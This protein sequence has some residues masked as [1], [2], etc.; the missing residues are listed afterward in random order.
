M[1]LAGAGDTDISDLDSLDNVDIIATTAEK[2]D[3][4]TRRHRDKGGMRFFNEVG[5]EGG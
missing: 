1:T 5:E 4:L 3:S 2:F